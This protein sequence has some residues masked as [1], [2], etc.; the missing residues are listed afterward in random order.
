MT[1]NKELQRDIEKL[2]DLYRSQQ[3]KKLVL[4]A[5]QLESRWVDSALAH[6][7]I[8]ASYVQL[9]ISD[10]AINHYEKSISIL[11]N[12]P[13]SY[14][15]LG[16]VQLE[17][18]LID[19]AVKCFSS[20]LKLDPK[21]ASAYFNRGNSHRQKKNFEEAIKD[22]QE[23]LRLTPLDVDTLN[24]L[25]AIY[26]EKGQLDEAINTFK[27]LVN[28]NPNYGK[29]YNNLGIAFKWKG[30]LHQAIDSFS[31]AVQMSPEEMTFWENL[32][33]TLS[34]SEINFSQYSIFYENT[35]W[36]LLKRQNTHNPIMI[37]QTIIRFLSKDASFARCFEHEAG[38]FQEKKFNVELINELSSFRLFLK[39]MELCPIA[40][41]AIE[42]I[43]TN[44][45]KL[46]LLDFW[47]IDK[48]CDLNKF[49]HAL[50]LQ[51][52]TNEYVYFQSAQ[53]LDTVDELVCLIER[54]LDQ[55]GVIKPT[56][57]AMVACY[58]P[59]NKFSWCKK[60]VRTEM[61]Q[62]LIK[63]QV[64]ER[65]C[66]QRLLR[67]MPTLTKIN[68][69]TSV[70]VRQQYEENS[71]P[72]W[73][74][75]VIF[76]QP[77][78][79]Y[80]LLRD[81]GL[82]PADDIKEIKAPKILVAGCGT[83]KHA[84]ATASR[85]KNSEIT[86]IDLSLSSLAYAKRK[87][88]EIGLNNI[89]YSQADIL[90]LKEHPTRYD[91][92]ESIGVLHHMEVPEDGL[93]ILKDLL[94]PGGLL[95]IGLYSEYAR[96]GVIQ[97]RNLIKKINHKGAIEEKIRNFRQSI[98]MKTSPE[99]KSL[100]YVTNWSDFFSMSECRDLFFHVKEHRFTLLEIKKMIDQMDLIFMGFEF[101][102]SAAPDGF[103]NRFKQDSNLLSLDCWDEYERDNPTTFLG[104]YQFWLRKKI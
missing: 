99:Y 55:G 86:A 13:K 61:N 88:N 38:D 9:G 92:V 72:R 94:N 18:G 16:V 65:H 10:S 64:D 34:L 66:E 54:E 87:T 78:S 40:D 2:L 33:S 63:R 100:F 14:N 104:M 76:N 75:S 6:E 90:D 89:H 5:K 19:E 41:V 101:N 97:S 62:T 50:A 67:V 17:I 74:N 69:K 32:G 80:D 43:L 52:Y 39:L 11:P 58:H 84:L 44:C 83:G 56:L 37:A 57:L 21:Y 103:K 25:G 27:E 60:I 48:V 28:I 85:F 8:A 29:G 35:L 59:L 71:Y 22:Y 93:A 81:I 7:I 49:L 77:I 4:M 73:V 31:K 45:R 91:I 46:I 3:Y 82:D 30:D 102:G 68:N 70:K 23:A 95:R 36:Q 42:K 51:C 20:A 26:Q 12:N 24:N 98:I 96:K 1:D 15:N 79:V 47:Q 53:E